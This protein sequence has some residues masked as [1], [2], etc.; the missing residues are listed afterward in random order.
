MGDVGVSSMVF[1]PDGS[2]VRFLP[3][4]LLRDGI[5]AFCVGQWTPRR[6]QPQSKRDPVPFRAP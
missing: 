6:T 5:E 4:S 1:A 3:R 2:F